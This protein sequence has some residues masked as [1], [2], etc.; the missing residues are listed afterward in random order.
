MDF[1]KKKRED[2][3]AKTSIKEGP[4]G[5]RGVAKYEKLLGVTAKEFEGKRV[6]DLGAG[7]ELRFGS[8]LKELGIHA[9]VI[10]MSPAFAERVHRERVIAAGHPEIVSKAVSG[11]G[12]ELP[13][14]DGSFD[15]IVSLHALQ[16]I[17][18]VEIQFNFLREIVR[19]LSSGGVAYVGPMNFLL[20]DLEQI[21]PKELGS[22]V[23][24]SLR[25]TLPAWMRFT[26]G[27]QVLT[28]R[29]K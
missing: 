10:S 7:S 14:A 3:R 18:E 11:L 24:I 4:E 1:E 25:E 15:R 19:T 9:E 26:K 2:V 17:S 28:I 27:L 21:L 13:F 20:G 16:Y 22:A 5:G 23:E 6:L 12:Q 29:K 8:E